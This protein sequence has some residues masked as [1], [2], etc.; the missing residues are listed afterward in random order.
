[1]WEYK[2]FQLYRT[3]WLELTGHFGGVISE[4]T[5]AFFMSIESLLAFTPSELSGSVSF[6]SSKKHG[7]HLGS[8]FCVSPNFYKTLTSFNPSPLYDYAEQNDLASRDVIFVPVWNSAQWMVVVINIT[9]KLTTLYDPVQNPINAK[10]AEEAASTVFKFFKEIRKKKDKR[11][12][13]GKRTSTKL[14]LEKKFPA[15]K[16]VNSGVFVLW[17]I[18]SQ[19]HTIEIPITNAFRSTL[20]TIL[21][22][23][24][25]VVHYNAVS[26]NDLEELSHD[27]P[28]DKDIV[29]LQ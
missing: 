26:H 25:D 28:S 5:M 24:I 14:F 17:Y 11:K 22:H 19:I 21:I 27:A 7:K 15:Q 8:Y 13:G 10:S 12:T 18:L 1:V 9:Q 2:N 3:D 29:M 4:R 6:S 16:M 23:D 20:A